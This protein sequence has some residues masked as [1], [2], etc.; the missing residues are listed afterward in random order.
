MPFEQIGQSAV[1]RLW[2][3]NSDTACEDMRPV[4]T[5][6]ISDLHLGAVSGADVARRPEVTERLAAALARADRVVV[7]GDLL[8]MRERRADEILEL[9]APVLA[10]IGSAT[11][12][13]VLCPGNHDYELVS[14]ALEGARLDGADLP[15]EG[16]YAAEAGV[17]SRRVAEMLAP[18]RVSVAYPGLWLRDDVWAT[19]GHYADVHLTVPRVESIFAHGVGRMVGAPARGGGAGA[20][21]GHRGA[22]VRVLARHRPERTG[23]PLDQG[24]QHLQGGLGARR[25]AAAPPACCWAGWP[26]R[27]RSRR[28][29]RLASGASARTSPRWSCA[30]PG[31]APWRRW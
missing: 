12:E 2:R 20:L 15:R 31:S 6:V 22:G 25:R 29:T 23:P 30:A 17:L 28:S 27:P 21:R 16:V 24:R 10:A 8:E 18:A 11:S 14:P 5:A 3:Q 9:A 13:I 1:K 4:A 26:Y 19:H 7:L